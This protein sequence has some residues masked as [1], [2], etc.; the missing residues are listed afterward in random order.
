MTIVRVANHNVRR[1]ATRFGLMAA[2]VLGVAALSQSAGADPPAENPTSE[3]HELPQVTIEARRQLERRVN[4]FVRRITDIPFSMQDSL[5]LWRDSLCFAVAG[6]P[7]EQGSFALGRLREIARATGLR[8]ARPGCKYNFIVIF[9][10]EPDKLLG[11]AFHLHPLEFNTNGG[12]T[13]LKNFIAPAKQQAVRAWHNTRVT[14]RSGVPIQLDGA[15]GSV[16]VQG[17]QVPVS[18]QYSPSRIER[19]DV[20]AFSLALVVIDT[21]YPKEFKL[22]QLI[23]YAAM[24]GLAQIPANEDLGDAPSILRLFGESPDAEPSGLTAWDSA[25]LRALY[26][27]DQGNTA[28]RSEIAVQMIHEVVR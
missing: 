13:P 22:G 25:F 3:E 23:D 27:S 16:S 14:T 10:A 9:S 8:V 26:H 19:Y 24:V 2:I 4:E 15:C 12:M 7:T 17:M 28:Q 21:S 1:R 11:K 20:S 6:L 5:P 18:C